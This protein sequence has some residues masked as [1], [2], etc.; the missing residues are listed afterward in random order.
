MNKRQFNEQLEIG[1]DWVWNFTY[2]LVWRLLKK[3]KKIYAASL[4]STF[5]NTP[6]MSPETC[7][8]HRCGQIVSAVC[9]PAGPFSLSLRTSKESPLNNN[10]SVCLNV[11][12]KS[13]AE[14]RQSRQKAA[15]RACAH[16]VSVSQVLVFNVAQRLPVGV[17]AAAAGFH[18]R[19]GLSLHHV[20]HLVIPVREKKETKDLSRLVPSYEFTTSFLNGAVLKTPADDDSAIRVSTDLLG[21]T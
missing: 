11:A 15:Q 2:L 9:L 13:A 18:L 7:S 1:Q 4:K 6:L 10:D 8:Q 19:Q 16:L 3:Q 12:S 21:T 20:T 14:L 17:A 5:A